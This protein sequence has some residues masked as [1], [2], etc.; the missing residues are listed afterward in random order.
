MD[1]ISIIVPVYKVEKYLDRCVESIVNQTY[2]NL[3]I[4]LVDDGSPDKCPVMCDAWVKKDSRIKVIHKENGGLSDAR[5]AGMERATGDYLGF[6][7]SDDWI[8]PEMYEKMMYAIQKDGS[9][10]VACDVEM[11]WENGTSS[12]MLTPHIN[13]VLDKYEAQKALIEESKLK[14]PVWYKLYRKE[15]VVGIPFEKEK[16][17]EDVFWSYLAIGKAEKISII[18]YLG[19]FYWQRSESI[20]G[21]KYSLKRL[22][23]MEA[24]CNRYKYMKYNFPSLEKKALCTIWENC[25]YHGQ[26]ALT[27][28]NKEDQEKVFEQ[29]DIIQQKYPIKYSDY[30]EMKLSHRVW[31]D[32]SRLSLKSVCIIKKVLKIGY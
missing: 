24:Y 12:R 26:M 7:D 27:Y 29:L 18:E 16:Y 14:Q 22:D 30:S 13:C 10:I 31:M 11:V 4:I 5:N 6:V 32:I 3:E 8:A 20:M 15:I 25:I 2:Q 17:H 23:A 1:L 28:L 9:D 21:E 19:Y